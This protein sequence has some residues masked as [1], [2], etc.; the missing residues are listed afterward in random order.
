[1]KSVV[2]SDLFESASLG[3]PSRPMIRE[4]FRS[5]FTGLDS[6]HVPAFSGPAGSATGLFVERRHWP[7]DRAGVTGVKGAG[8][9]TEPS[10]ACTFSGAAV[11]AALCKTKITG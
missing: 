8:H 7:F 9:F 11:A 6:D 3:F 10:F 2:L 5:A 1:M 4:A